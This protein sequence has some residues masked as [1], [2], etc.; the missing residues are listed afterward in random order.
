MTRSQSMRDSG[1]YRRK[2][3]CSAKV[4]KKGRASGYSYFPGRLWWECLRRL[5]IDHSY[6]SS[7]LL[8]W[9]VVLALLRTRVLG[10]LCRGTARGP[11]RVKQVGS[12]I[13]N[14]IFEDAH[15]LIDQGGRQKEWRYDLPGPDCEINVSPGCWLQI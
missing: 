15:R 6:S 14:R 4:G 8:F 12:H 10:L 7:R 13:R 1:C 11:V 5:V 3:E 9:P 2:Y